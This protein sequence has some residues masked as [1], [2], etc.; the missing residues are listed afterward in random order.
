M[1]ARMQFQLL[2]ILIV[3][4]GYPLSTKA[5][6]SGT[7]SYISVEITSTETPASATPV[8]PTKSIPTSSFKTKGSYE[9]FINTNSDSSNG[10]LGGNDSNNQNNTNIRK[11]PYLSTT[12]ANEITTPATKTTSQTVESVTVSPKITSLKNRYKPQETPVLST[13]SPKAINIVKQEENGGSGTRT[14]TNTEEMVKNI[15]TKSNSLV[16]GLNKR[17]FIRTSDKVNSSGTSYSSGGALWQ[18]QHLT[19]SQLSL[20][21]SAS[22][23]AKTTPSS[24]ELSLA[25]KT[26]MTTATTTTIS[27]STTTMTPESTPVNFSS[28][29]TGYINITSQAGSNAYLPCNVKHLTKRKTISWIRM[30]DKHII[31]VNKTIF[32]ND[33]RFHSNFLHDADHWSLQIKYINKSDEGLYECQVSADPKISILVYLH[34]VEPTIHFQ[35]DTNQHIKDGSEM[36]LKCVIKDAVEVP[37]FVNWFF[38][39]QPIYLPNNLGWE[40]KIE[41]VNSSLADRFDMIASLRIPSIGKSNSGNYTCLPS[42]SEGTTV[43]VHVHKGDSAESASAITSSGYTFQY[44][45]VVSTLISLVT[46]CR[47]ILI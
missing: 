35:G 14:T 27:S 36:T 42:N 5:T 6:D 19:K 13:S 37:W 4:F 1:I 31:A 25:T 21:S 20:S 32:V 43:V 11:K 17:S 41:K 30:V 38:N 3:P 29:S 40:S 33:G 39:D 18:S 23:L 34:V 8:T 2:F 7:S 9:H 28:Y 44:S 47:Q 24:W 26:P 22:K 46:T 45:I 10:R 15:Q 16:Y 12:F